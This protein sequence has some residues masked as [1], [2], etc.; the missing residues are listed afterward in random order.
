MYFQIISQITRPDK[1][2]DFNSITC[3]YL[4]HIKL[5]NTEEHA[6]VVFIMKIHAACFTQ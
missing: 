4:T 3:F 5:L 1:M 2:N 6:K